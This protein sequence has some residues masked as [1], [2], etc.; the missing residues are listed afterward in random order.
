MES[1]KQGHCRR[2]L[3]QFQTARQEFLASKGLKK[4]TPDERQAEA[5][6]VL[7]SESDFLELANWVSY[8]CKYALR[9]WL[10]L[11]QQVKDWEQSNSK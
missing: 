11:S 2:L 10:T 6:K 7:E 5:E 3:V 9:F 1:A 4:E 8:C